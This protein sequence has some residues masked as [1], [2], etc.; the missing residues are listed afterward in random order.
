MVVSEDEAR[1]GTF[2]AQWS[3]V[4]SLGQNLQPFNG[5]DDDSIWEKISRMGRKKTQTI[6]KKNQIGR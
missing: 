1:S 2:N 4:A 3:L 6:T 5:N